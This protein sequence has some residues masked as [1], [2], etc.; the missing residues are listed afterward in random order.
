MIATAE[1]SA[2]ELAI[3]EATA[4]V[5]HYVATG[6][7][8]EVDVFEL[9]A[10]CSV[11]GLSLPANIWDRSGLEAVVLEY[12][13]QERLGRI[14][15][16]GEWEAMSNARKI[17]LLHEV[18]NAEGD[19]TYIDP[20]TGYTVFTFFAHLKRGDCCGVKPREEI[21][22]DGKSYERIHRCRHCP[23]TDP[24]EIKSSKMEAL[25]DRTKVIEAARERT[26]ELYTGNGEVS[27]PTLFGRL[28][29]S[30]GSGVTKEQDETEVGSSLSHQG[31]NEVASMRKFGKAVKIDKPIKEEVQC[32]D[33]G[34]EKILTCTRCNG[35]TFLCA[36]ELMKC[37]QCQAKGYHP[38]MSCTPFRPPSRSSFNS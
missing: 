8:S 29:E 36:P 26:Q 23:Y 27:G 33:C 28:K 24:G 38:C 12:A 14:R 19:V 32:E 20:E 9:A 6:K 11:K 2:D 34:D 22:E 21:G 7:L 25:R 10:F 17:R 35:F 4:R 30:N 3:V 31:A 37:P 1:L 16:G 13:R 5:G 15:K 18:C